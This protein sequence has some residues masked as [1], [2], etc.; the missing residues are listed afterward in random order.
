MA[1][2]LIQNA[3]RMTGNSRSLLDLIIINCEEKVMQSGV[4]TIGISDH[5]IT[6]CTR[7]L[8]KDQGKNFIEMRSTKKYNIDELIEKLS[9]GNWSKV[10]MNRNVNS[11][12]IA[13][14]EIF[15]SVLNDVTSLREVKVKSKT[16]P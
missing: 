1:L 13:F 9:K 14:C 15:T 10:Y 7:K 12:W 3:T 5:S 4:L 8:K 11:A 6:F 2:K 16:E